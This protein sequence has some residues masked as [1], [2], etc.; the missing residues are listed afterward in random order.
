MASD[1]ANSLFTTMELALKFVL[2][3][4]ED[5]IDHVRFGAV[6][7]SWHSIVKLYHQD[8]PFMT[9]VPMLMIPT[10]R[11]SRTT[12]SLYS[13]PAGRV[14]PFQLFVPYNKRC[15]GCSHGWIATVD[16]NNVIRLLNPFKKV[17]DITLP[18]IAPIV[19]HKYF[20][21]LNIHKVTLSA[22]PI[23]RPKD[24]VVVAI[25]SLRCCLAFIKAG[26]KFWTYIDT[27][28]YFQFTDVAFYKGRVYASNRYKSIVSFKLRYSKDPSGTEKMVPDIVL[29]GGWHN[30]KRFSHQSYLVKSLEGDLWMVRRFLAFED[31]PDN[32]LPHSIGTKNFKVYKL[33]LDPESGRLLQKLRLRSLGDNVLF[34]GDNDSVSVSA[35]CFS[36]CLQ[37]DS[38][39]FA[40]DNIITESRPYPHGPFDLGIYNVKDGSFGSHCPYSPSFRR[41]PPPFWVIPP[42]VLD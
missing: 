32:V 25:H 8:N 17:A 29:E 39:Y 12:R 15:C 33:E 23:R 14:Y 3:K 11:K 13:I 9:N 10:K 36:N 34:V 20:Y 24:Y 38:I 21:E 26:Q 7:K 31:V 18:Q 37:K 1:N 19:P 40:D 27:I 22:D 28:D 4:L 35:S 42:F 5:R 16:E 2:D 30:Y 41:M 6:C